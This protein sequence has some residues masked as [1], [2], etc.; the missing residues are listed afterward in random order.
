[1]G[2]MDVCHA[3]DNYKIC[4]IIAQVCFAHEEY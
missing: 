3:R 2:K 1:M 4:T